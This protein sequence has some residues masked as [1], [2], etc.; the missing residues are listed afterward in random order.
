MLRTLLAAL[1]LA[2]SMAPS[3]AEVSNGGIATSPEKPGSET[4]AESQDDSPST[5]SSDQTRHGGTEA[6][7]K[8]TLSL[9]RVEPMDQ[10]PPAEDNK[11]IEIEPIFVTATKRKASLRDLPASISAFSGE[12]LE[13]SGASE[14]RDIL[15]Q[16]PG[17]QQTELQPDFFQISVRGIQTDPGGNTPAATGLFIDD[18]PFNDPFL[19]Q[20]RPD[21]TPFDLQGIEVLKGPQGTL[22][23]GSGLA[24]AVRYKLADAV[25]GVWELKS[26]TQYQD[27][28]DGSPNRTGGASLNL[29]IGDNS[30]ALRLVGV[31]RL[32]GGV[33]DDLR[34]DVTDTD[35]TA[36]SSGRALLRWNVNEQFSVK[37]KALR[38]E[39]KADDVPL[40][41]NTQGRLE[42]ERA[43]L[44]KS[45]SVTRFEIYGLDLNFKGPWGEVVSTTNIL[46]KFGDL[47]TAYGERLLEA[48][49]AGD[50]IGIPTIADVDGLVQEIRVLS[51]DNAG[52]NWQWL[53]GAFAHDYKSLT[54]QKLIVNTVATG[55]QLELLDFVADVTAKEF[56]VFGE[57]SRFFGE[58]WQ[59]T[60]G[61][62]AYSVETGGSVVTS[63]L[64]VPDG[65]NRNDADT[66]STGVNPKLA[67]QY[68][69]SKNITSYFSVARGFRF[70]GI[71]ITGPSTANPNV[72][73]TY[74]P[75]SLW[76]YELGLRTQWL[77]NRL[78]VDG[79]VFFI[80]WRDPQVQT[81]T[82]GE[83]PFNVTANVG[84]ARSYGGELALRYLPS[85]KGLHLGLSAAYTNA[86]TTEPFIDPSGETV[87]DG[88][89]LPGYAD[90]QVTG[91][92]TYVRSIGDNRFDASLTHVIQGEGAS[93][94]LQS[95]EIYDYHVTDLRTGI[96]K[97]RWSGRPRLSFGVTNLTDERVV[98][99][100]LA[101]GETNITTVYNRPRTLDLRLDLSF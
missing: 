13:N 70:G 25:P 4:L 5:G 32:T 44:P 68:E 57:A 79:A 99:S 33:I 78:Q 6:E 12:E 61:M 94:L 38:Q 47:S 75:D 96:T 87:R 27:V 49:D 100:A 85:I 95:I 58:R 45:P 101:F 35:R 3:A 8:T 18:V 29:P 53:V 72:P 98:V 88:T 26:F 50:P 34:N 59:L 89:R 28:E 83:V 54:K 24:G 1:L 11:P 36:S 82:G 51:P 37:L 74:S 66:R 10:I 31:R 22:F 77:E 81:S 52:R 97:T 19:N 55:E 40:A 67:L 48:E 14:L 30:A 73:E 21:L 9:V 16:I 63:G 86:R 20:V 92:V 46:E 65:E 41:E 90:F 15:R 69:A 2:V 60:L 64:V 39:N 56:A 71:Q 80:D 76:N 23:G 43:L 62:R 91:V 93:D 42:R 84:G 7:I 17:V